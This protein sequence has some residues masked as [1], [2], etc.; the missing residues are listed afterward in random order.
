MLDSILAM[1]RLAYVLLAVCVFLQPALV[2]AQFSMISITSPVEGQVIQGAV[3]VTGS[4]AMPDFVSAEISFSYPNDPTGTWF[5]VAQADQQVESGTLAT[6]DTTLIT[7]GNYTLR[8]HV[9]LADGS[10]RDV[11][12][13]ELRVRNYTPVETSTPAPAAAAD[14]TPLPTVAPTATLYPTPTQLPSNPA[15][16]TSSEVWTS[17]LYGGLA[18]IVLIA[19]V[20]IYLRLRRN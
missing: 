2:R 14:A 3:T 20:W 15:E 5:L 18:V 12:V 19:F 16:I 8:L 4:S 6:W 9:T 1:K 11:T 13:P 17:L 7:D 10:T